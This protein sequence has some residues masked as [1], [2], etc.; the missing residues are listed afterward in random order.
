M[1]RPVGRVQRIETLAG[2]S[3]PATEAVVANSL[4]QAASVADALTAFR[5]DRLTPLRAVEHGTDE[6]ARAAA[7]I[8]KALRDAVAADEFT[9]KLRP[10]LSGADDAIFEWLADGQPR[11]PDVQWPT[12]TDAVDVTI[13]RPKAVHGGITRAKGDPPTHVLNAL[14]AFLAAHHNEQVIVEWRVDE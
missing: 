5:W 12:G 2:A 11:V 4:S 8:L 7:R 9:R 3:L 13:D 1:R 10:A 6:R 14:T